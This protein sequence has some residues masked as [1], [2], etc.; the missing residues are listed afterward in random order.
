MKLKSQIVNL[1]KT[2]SSLM[3]CSKNIVSKLCLTTKEYISTVQ[4]K[5][6]ILILIDSGENN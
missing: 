2:E 6:S 3:V 5:I 1:I 4:K